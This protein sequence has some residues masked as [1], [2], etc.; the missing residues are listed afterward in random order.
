MKEMII[1]LLQKPTGALE[2]LKKNS[3]MKN[4]EKKPYKAS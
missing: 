2:E 3:M 4:E 1:S